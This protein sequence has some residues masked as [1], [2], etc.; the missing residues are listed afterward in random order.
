MGIFS[1]VQRRRLELDEE[2]FKEEVRAHL[3]IAA[4]ERA[5]DGEDPREARYAALANS[6]T[7]HSPPTRLAM[8]GHR[9]GW[10]A[11]HDQW[12]DVRYAIRAL[13]KKRRLFID[14]HRGPDA[15]HR[16]ERG[17]VHAAQGFRAHP[18]RRGERCRGHRRD[19]SRDRQRSR[20]TAVVPGI[21]VLP[22]SPS[23]VR[24]SDGLRG[25]DGE[26]RARTARSP[27]LGGDR[28]VQLFRRP[29]RPCAAWPHAAGIRRNRPRTPPGCRHQRRSL[30]PRFQR[31]SCASSDALSRSTTRS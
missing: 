9:R 11:L 30:A 21:S 23:R 25:H 12:S 26:P 1:W 3:E 14:G 18:A 13:A 22:R 8:C 15:R 19:L 7:S 31:R 4:Q 28:H 20:D 10:R 27:G 6:A 5:A 29:R 17:G 16:I 24:K 2:D